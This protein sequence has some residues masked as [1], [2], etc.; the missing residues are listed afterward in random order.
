MGSLHSRV[1]KILPQVYAFYTSFVLCPQQ[2]CM[3]QNRK[4]IR[5]EDYQ[6]VAYVF[7]TNIIIIL[8]GGRVL[9]FRIGKW[10]CR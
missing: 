10:R 2:A 1:V 3:L 7:I 6:C 5:A 4:K 8:V 9:S